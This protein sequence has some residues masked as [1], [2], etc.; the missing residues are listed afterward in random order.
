MTDMRSAIIP[1]SDQ[2]SADDLLAGP[3]TIC[4]ARVEVRASPDQPVSVFYDGDDGRPWKPCKSMSRVLVAAWGSD[5][6]VYVGR[7]VT[8]YRDPTVKWGGLAVGGIRVS[9]MS[10]IEREMVMALTETKGKR[11]PFKVKPLAST[12]RQEPRTPAPEQSSTHPTTTLSARADRF[13][14]ALR[15]STDLT[16]LTRTWQ[17]AGDLRDDLLAGDPDRH[18]EIERV[19]EMLDAEMDSGTDDGFPGDQS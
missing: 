5:A 1:K 13:E 7:S 14:A 12:P 4:I 10:D 18:A 2:I 6:K 3:L 8:L 16:I 19:Y 9:H 11:T 17:R 15:G